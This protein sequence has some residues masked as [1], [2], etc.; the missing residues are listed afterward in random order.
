MRYNSSS[1]SSWSRTSRSLPIKAC[2]TSV[3]LCL[4]SLMK[5]GIG[6]TQAIPACVHRAMDINLRSRT[7]AARCSESLSG[8][9]EASSFAAPARHP[10][11]A[12]PLARPGRVVQQS[13]IQ[14]DYRAFSLRGWLLL[15]LPECPFNRELVATEPLKT[16]SFGPRIVLVSIRHCT[17]ILQA[18]ATREVGKVISKANNHAEAIREAA[19]QL[20][21]LNQE[22]QA[23]CGPLHDVAT[24]RQVLET[25]MHCRDIY[26][27]PL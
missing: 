20:F 5:R 22:L 23:T 27:L 26:T 14:Q 18:L 25:G 6:L 17:F 21:Y 2:K 9:Q 13:E 10:T 11:E 12:S 24:A 4:H 16:G 1:S 15:L 3:K 7:W 19:D 8:S